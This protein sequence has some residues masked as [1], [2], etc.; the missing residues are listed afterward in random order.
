MNLVTGKVEKI[1]GSQYSDPTNTWHPSP[2]HRHIISG[3][4]MSNY[5]MAPSR[6]SLAI[7]DA[8]FKQVECEFMESIGTEVM[9][10][11]PSSYTS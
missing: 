1:P 4:S 6:S 7:L 2:I 11:I 10:Y 8:K 3:N 9:I 5:L